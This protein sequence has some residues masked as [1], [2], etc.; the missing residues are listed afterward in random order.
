MKD[1]LN[2]WQRNGK[3]LPELGRPLEGRSVHVCHSDISSAI[4]INPNEGYLKVLIE[5]DNEEDRIL[6][7]ILFGN[8][9][10]NK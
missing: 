10:K 1:N 3:Y 7:E 6:L 4:P 2:V 9:F 8:K 5:S